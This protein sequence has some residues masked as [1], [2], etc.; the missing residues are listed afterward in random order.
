MNECWGQMSHN[1]SKD[2][3][4]P[5]E[6]PKDPHWIFPR[7]PIHEIATLMGIFIYGFCPGQDSFPTASAGTL[8]TSI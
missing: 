3:R 4:P 2:N 8:R 7:C 6:E 5:W 1:I